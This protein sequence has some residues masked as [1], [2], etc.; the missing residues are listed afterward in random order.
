MLPTGY[1]L[2]AL[3]LVELPRLLL[4]T[5]R[6][7]EPPH[8]RVDPDG[9][10]AELRSQVPPDE[11]ADFDQT[12]REAR[13]VMDMH[14]DN[15]P[16]T[17]EWPMGLLRRALLAA[18]RR[19]EARGAVERAA[20]AVELTPDEARRALSGGT[21]SAAALAARRDRRIELAAIDPPILLG[22]PEPEPPLDVLPGPLAEL[23]GMI[24][25]AFAH[26]G[27]DGAGEAR[28]A[29]DADRWSGVGVGVGRLVATARVAGSAEEAIE[30]LDPGD[31]LVVRATSPA[32][33]AVLA[34]AGG[35]VTADG[36]AMSHAAVLARELGIP[37]VVGAPGA[38][39]IPDGA[40]I[41]LDADGG[42]VRL[43]HPD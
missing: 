34:I 2:T 24:R 19:L 12:L 22:E 9:V 10:A 31:V 1:D 14:D 27:M 13:A 6:T 21:P 3:T 40:T 23:V 38:L 36:G 4:D 37:A 32:F 25:V 42:L 11:R 28:P 18:G 35:V 43:V 8:R 20:D 5:I 15:G 33:N 39:E 16:L 7:A 29:A 41:E 17:V 30:R 26:L